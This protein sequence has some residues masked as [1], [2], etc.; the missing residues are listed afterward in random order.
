LYKLVKE[1]GK[2]IQNVRTMGTDLTTS[3]ENNMESQLQ[4]NELRKAQRELNDAFSFRRSI[5]ANPY[6]DEAFSTTV[7]TPREPSVLDASTL[8]GATTAATAG[9]AA[10]ATGGPKKMRRKRVVIKK[11]QPAETSNPDTLEMPESGTT[12]VTTTTSATQNTNDS[13][14]A[15]DPFI[16]DSSGYTKEEE[17][18]INADFDKYTLGTGGGGAGDADDDNDTSAYRKQYN[19]YG[20]PP[21]VPQKQEVAQSRFQQQLSGTWNEQVM[22]NGDALEPV[23]KIM[24]LLAVLEEEK[25]AATKRL[26]DEFRKRAEMD[27]AYYQKQRQLLKDASIQIQQEQQ[28]QQQ[29]QEQKTE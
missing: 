1:I 20:L 21:P 14:R 9:G 25:I 11:K 29:K 22:R 28:Q 6:E 18:A 16:R 17:D 12:S 19:E 24:Q 10:T 4:L 3:F 26:E 7:E 13:S 8:A 15:M 23:G 5:N 27:E 2:F